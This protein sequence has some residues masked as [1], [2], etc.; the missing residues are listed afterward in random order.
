M[1]AGCRDCSTARR[2]AATVPVLPLRRSSDCRTRRSARPWYRSAVPKK[3]T[4]RRR[5]RE[6][7]GT[8]PYR[9]RD[10][11]PFQRPV[12]SSRS[13]WYGPV[14]QERT[15][16]GWMRHPHRPAGRRRSRGC[17]GG[18]EAP[19][20]EWRRRP[21]SSCCTPGRCRTVSDCCAG[22]CAPPVRSAHNR[23]WRRC[24]EAAG[25]SSETGA[26]TGR[27]PNA[28]RGQRFFECRVAGRSRSRSSCVI[29]PLRSECGSVRCVP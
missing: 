11:C 25:G 17:C 13:P 18:A 15:D 24:S 16:H 7:G 12:C 2:R 28:S 4:E 1:R 29:R 19:A 5:I 8:A 26:V 23:G 27:W 20:G 21:V 9:M 6:N 14:P 22:W 3:R 10:P